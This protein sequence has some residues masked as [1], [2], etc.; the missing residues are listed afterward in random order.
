L[1]TRLYTGPD[2]RPR[3]YRLKPAALVHWP[4]YIAAFSEN[5]TMDNGQPTARTKSLFEESPVFRMAC[6]QLEAVAEVIDL[7]R[8]ILERLINPKR[9]LVVSVPIR[10]DDGKTNNF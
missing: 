8:N 6:R 2:N 9:S 7:D 3:S 10:M 5:L 4:H 1:R